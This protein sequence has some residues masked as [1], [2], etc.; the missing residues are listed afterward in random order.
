MVGFGEHPRDHQCYLFWG[1]DHYSPVRPSE[2][3]CRQIRITPE[4]KSAPSGKTYK[5]ELIVDPRLL[6]L[7]PQP[8]KKYI[9]MAGY[10]HAP[11]QIRPDGIRFDFQNLPMTT[12]PGAVS[13][14]RLSGK[15]T[16][17]KTDMDSFEDMVSGW[18]TVKCED[19]R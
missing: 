3:I 16:A 19:L 18:N 14:F 2:R 5:V 9:V 7:E 15:V 17:R 8:G 11:R 4:G 13:A 12:T 6:D 1:Y 10:T